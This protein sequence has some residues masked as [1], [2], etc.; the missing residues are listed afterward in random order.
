MDAWIWYLFTVQKFLDFNCHIKCSYNDTVQKVLWY[1][2]YSNWVFIVVAVVAAVVVVIIP[3]WPHPVVP[4]TPQGADP[5][6]WQ[7]WHCCRRRLL[8][9]H[10]NL[11]TTGRCPT[12]HSCR[13]WSRESQL[14]SLLTIWRPRDFYCCFSRPIGATAPPRLLCWRS[15]R[16]FW[17]RSTTKCFH[18]AW[19]Q[20][21]NVR[22]DG[23][24]D[25][26]CR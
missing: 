14:S 16:M 9:S 3:W 13:S 22:A 23:Q 10:M 1:R 15:C 8:W 25:P 12:C 19:V 2:Q 11:R 7:L 4:C 18:D 21:S 20:L 26:Q 5:R 17:P 24:F 6:R